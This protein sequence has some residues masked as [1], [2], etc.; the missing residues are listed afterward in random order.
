MNTVSLIL[1]FPCHT[2]VCLY[3][4]SQYMDIVVLWPFKMKFNLQFCL[5]P[6]VFSQYHT[7]KSLENKYL[8]VQFVFFFYTIAIY[9]YKFVN[10]R[11]DEGKCYRLQPI[12]Q[13]K[14]YKFLNNIK[15]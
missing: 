13:S 7:D 15:Y 3:G 1:M 5:H 8:I 12:V 6:Y 11:V 4:I 14:Y 10:I 9:F 2:Y